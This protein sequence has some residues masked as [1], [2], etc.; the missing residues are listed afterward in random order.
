MAQL[1]S[2]PTDMF[3]GRLQGK[4]SEDKEYV[5]NKQNR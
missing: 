2:R 5:V 4:T 3:I 1:I